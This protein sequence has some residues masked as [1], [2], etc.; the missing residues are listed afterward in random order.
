MACLLTNFSLLFQLC[1][2]DSST[3]LP[4]NTIDVTSMKD[5]LASISSSASFRV[6]S[7][8]ILISAAL[9]PSLRVEYKVGVYF[10]IRMSLNDSILS[11]LM[12]TIYTGGHHH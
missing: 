1:R 8:S 11:I 9:L 4:T 10:F 7:N 12:Y 3:T 5:S 6:V 2:E